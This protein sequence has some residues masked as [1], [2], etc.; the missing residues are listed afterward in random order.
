MGTGLE[1]DWLMLRHEHST[2][3]NGLFEEG[4]RRLRPSPP[5]DDTSPMTICRGDHSAS[6]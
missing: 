5:Q 1:S 3:V 6:P 4:K 2:L